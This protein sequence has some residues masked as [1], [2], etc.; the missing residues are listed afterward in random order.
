MIR[1]QAY[2]FMKSP[3]KGE[4]QRICLQS[5]HLYICATEQSELRDKINTVLSQ[6][7]IQ[8]KKAFFIGQRIWTMTRC[9][10]RL[11]PAVFVSVSAQS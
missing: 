10:N 7:Q 4:F 1:A 6:P 2:P 8:I 5:Q 3:T 11:Q 9:K